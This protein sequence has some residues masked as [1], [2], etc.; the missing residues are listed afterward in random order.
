MVRT[1]KWLT[2]LSPE[3]APSEAARQSLKL[4]LADVWLCAPL[5]AK[6][7]E[8]DAEYVHQLRVS[9]R[10]ADAAMRL[11]AELAPAKRL[12]A[13][14]KRLRRI[15]R[16]AGDARDLDVLIERI[17]GLKLPGEEP[18]RDRLLKQLKRERKAAQKP[19]VRAIKVE[20]QNGFKRATRELTERI[21]WRR[22]GPEPEFAAWARTRFQPLVD[23]FFAVASGDLS[24]VGN[25][26]QMRIHG[27]Q[28][29]YAMELLSVA[30]EG[31]FRSELY[32]IFEDVQTELGRINDHASAIA[33]F[34][35]RMQSR[36]YERCRSVMSELLDTERSSLHQDSDRFRD[37]WSVDRA[38]SMQLQFDA[39]IQADPRNSFSSDSTTVVGDS[40]S[41]SAVG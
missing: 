1:Q 28:V 8:K 33:F 9:V 37:W 11:Y 13:T 17:A 26:H 19:L 39:A 21:R 29:R 10:R 7:H 16:A 40:S 24:Q 22:E 5:A 6:Q 30:F 20:K 18:G 4:R 15:R 25:L 27:K 34:E 38:R 41:V 32:P 2:G 14:R 31:T 23:E 12:R 35:G 36:K 3:G